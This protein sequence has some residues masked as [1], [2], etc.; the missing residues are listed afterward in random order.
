MTSANR[1]PSS[2]FE[3]HIEELLVEG[4]PARHASRFEQALGGELQ[5][6]IQ[7]AQQRSGQK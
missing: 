4:L 2:G 7:Q 3:L 5:R 1:R 6:L